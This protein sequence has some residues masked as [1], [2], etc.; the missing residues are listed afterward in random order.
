MNYLSLCLSLWINYLRQIIKKKIFISIVMMISFTRPV[1]CQ[2]SFYRKV[3]KISKKLVY[4][5]DEFRD[6]SLLWI[7]HDTAILE[8]QF[9]AQLFTCA[10]QL[11]VPVFSVNLE[12]PTHPLYKGSREDQTL[13]QILSCDILHTVLIPGIMLQTFSEMYRRG[14]TNW[15]IIPPPPKLYI[16]QKTSRYRSNQYAIYCNQ[17]TN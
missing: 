8:Q 12:G 11:A 9:K 13:L 15:I 6:Q 3:H 10:I 16:S 17:M 14:Y 4:L 7:I 5:V 1:C 2:N